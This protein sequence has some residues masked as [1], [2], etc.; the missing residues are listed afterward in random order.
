MTQAFKCKFDLKNLVSDNAFEHPKVENFFYE[1]YLRDYND[2]LID[3]PI[4]IENFSGDTGG[5][6]NR[7]GDKKRWVLTRRFFIFDTVSG[8]RQNEYPS[9][10][11]VV[12]RYPR[13]MTFEIKLDIENE[14]MIYLPYLRIDYRERTLSFIKNTNSEAEIE[15]GT[16]YMSSTAKFW[17]SAMAIWYTLIV[18]MLIIVIVKMQV[19]LSKPQVN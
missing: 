15:F 10:A 2:E 16:Y 7:N 8:V 12:A 13:K 9:G 3:V 11:P 6:P 19:Q 4:L 1:L 18:L 5:F 17:E 14:E